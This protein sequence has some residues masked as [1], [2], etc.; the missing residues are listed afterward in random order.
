ME[1]ADGVTK[2]EIE[3]LIAG[4]SIEKPIHEDITYGEIY[5][6]QDNLWNFM[7]FTGYLKAIGERSENDVNYATLVIPNRE[8]RYIYSQKI[9]KWFDSEIVK[10]SD[11]S[12]LF[13]ATSQSRMR[14]FL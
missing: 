5:K 11:R 9:I 14:S 13:T 6:D 3:R 8:T 2:G 1:R 12:A 10:K 7:Y 4:G